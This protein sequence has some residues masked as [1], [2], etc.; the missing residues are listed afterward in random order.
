MANIY[1]SYSNVST[2]MQMSL[3]D[4]KGKLVRELSSMKGAEMDNYNMAK[5]ELFV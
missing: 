5:T 1:N 4:N 3:M 2:P